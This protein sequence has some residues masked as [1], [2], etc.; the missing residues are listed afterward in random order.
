M[1][2]S[3]ERQTTLQLPVSLFKKLTVYSEK[4]GMST[5]QIGLILLDEGIKQNFYKQIIL[6]NIEEEEKKGN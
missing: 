2:E 1:K 4:W 5:R 3:K 6:K